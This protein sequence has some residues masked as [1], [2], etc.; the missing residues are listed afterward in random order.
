MEGP[1]IGKT[2]DREGFGLLANFFYFRGDFVGGVSRTAAMIF[3]PGSS[4]E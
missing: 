3:R 2:A 1:K 4:A